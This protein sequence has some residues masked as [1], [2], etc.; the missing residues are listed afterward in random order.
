MNTAENQQALDAAFRK[1]LDTPYEVS[2][3]RR[4][5]TLQAQ[6][7]AIRAVERP[8]GRYSIA[9]AIVLL[10]V[11]TGE[12]FRVGKAAWDGEL[13]AYAPG[14]RKPIDTKGNDPKNWTQ[15]DASAEVYWHDINAWLAKEFPEV[16]Y[17]FPKPSAPALEI[18]GD[19]DTVIEA[20]QAAPAKVGEGKTG[21][22]KQKV[23]IAFAG[24][25]FDCDKWSKYLGDP[26]QWLEKCR[27]ERGN[28][29]ASATWNPVLIAVELLDKHVPIK[30]LDAVF[31]GLKDWADEWQKKTELLR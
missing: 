25:H 13:R 19:G 4:K 31:V 15:Y 3:A 11:E 12:Y 23:I 26:P 16:S 29:K 8:E 7:D 22:T 2:N 30:K 14:S 21:I 24:L 1:L 10:L 20:K 9:D 27:L 17:K 6:A 28:K 5:E 18:V